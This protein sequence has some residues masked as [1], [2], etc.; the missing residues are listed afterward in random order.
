[1]L[2][3]F[4]LEDTI[5][6][7]ANLQKATLTN[8]NLQGANLFEANLNQTAL[9][10][11]NLQNARNLTEQQLVTAFSLTQAI[12]PDGSRYNGRY[13]LYGDYKETGAEAMAHCYGVSLEEYLAGQEWARE[14][15]PRLRREVG[16]DPDTGE[17]LPPTNGTEPQPADAPAQ[18]TPRRNG[19]RHKGSIVA[20][21]A[22][23]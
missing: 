3:A 5:L 11:A 14:N 16:L 20:H 2:S 13:N 1:M 6:S 17:P 18:P 10:L 23:R 7:K 8:A 22:R 19:Q 21:R 12:M 4:N 9:A 15:L